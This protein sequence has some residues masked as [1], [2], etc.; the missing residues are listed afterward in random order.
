MYLDSM[1]QPAKVQRQASIGEGSQTVS[2]SSLPEHRLQSNG[3][4]MCK[5]LG[6]VDTGEEAKSPQRITDELSVATVQTHGSKYANFY[7]AP[8]VHVQLCLVFMCPCVQ[9][10]VPRSRRHRKF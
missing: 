6:C 4:P 3:H 10:V 7:T 5:A 2:K 8:A 1:I 9:L